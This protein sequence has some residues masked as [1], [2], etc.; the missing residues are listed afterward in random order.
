MSVFDV[1]RQ[2]ILKKDGEM[3]VVGL[4]FVKNVI[5]TV[6]SCCLQMSHVIS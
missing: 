6:T 1:E 3:D 5:V 2:F 4:L